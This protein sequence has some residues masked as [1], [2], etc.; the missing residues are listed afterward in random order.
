MNKEINNG[1]CTLCFHTFPKELYNTK[2]IL[3]ENQELVCLLPLKE[4]L[5]LIYTKYMLTH[6]PNFGVPFSRLSSVK[7]YIES[8]HLK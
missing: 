6:L 5:P 4:F 7:N 8:V 3:V 1:I 2:T